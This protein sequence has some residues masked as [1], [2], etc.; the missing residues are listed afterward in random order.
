MVVHWSKQEYKCLASASYN[1]RGFHGDSWR[2]QA[3][4]MGPKLSTQFL[5]SEDEG[6]IQDRVQNNPQESVDGQR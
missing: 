3:A 6:Y 2:L 5:A 4:G 1:D